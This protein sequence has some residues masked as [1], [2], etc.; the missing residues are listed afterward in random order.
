M[1]IEVST[2]CNWLTKLHLDVTKKFRL[3]IDVCQIPPKDGIYNIFYVCEPAVIYPHVIPWIKQN[4][5]HFDLVLSHDKRV[6]Q[7]CPNSHPFYWMRSWITPD[8]LTESFTSK[9]YVTFICG[10]NNMCQGHLERRS[11]WL[12]QNEIKIPKIMFYSTRINGQLQRFENNR[13]LPKTTKLPAFKDAMFHI[14]MEN[15]QI[16]GYFSEKIIDC[17]LTW[18]VPIYLGCP[19]IDDFFDING[20]IVA[21]NI[22]DIINICNN[23]SEDDYYYRM[24]FMKKNREIALTKYMHDYND[25]FQFHLKPIIDNI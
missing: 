7:T 17:F 25:S 18:T 3:I 11:C 5:Q 2:I 19:N 16:E 12:R 23:L 10:G 14:A 9:F 4:Y 24:E 8:E 21:K 20:I 13:P 6:L 15:C 22:D 1:D